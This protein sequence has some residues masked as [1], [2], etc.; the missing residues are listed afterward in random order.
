MIIV[1]LFEDYINSL[2][3]KKKTLGDILPELSKYAEKCKS[4]IDELEE[5][6][7]K[8]DS[9]MILEVIVDNIKSSINILDE[10]IDKITD[11]DKITIFFDEYKNSIV[12][13]AKDIVDILKKDENMVGIAKVID[14]IYQVYNDIVSNK[15][16]EYND[17][18]DDYRVSLKKIFD[19]IK[20]EVESKLSNFNIES[21]LQ[22]V[23]L[24]KSG[25]NTD[26]TYNSGDTVRYKMNN[27]DIN[28]A[29][30]SNNQESLKDTNNI[31]LYNKNS[32]QFE[33]DKSNIIEIVKRTA[34]ISSKIK[35]DLKDIS[36]DSG[37]LKKLSAFL[38]E[39]KSGSE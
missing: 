6:S 35:S 17:K 13:I 28:T 29:T 30:V 18:V 23:N 12:F 21:V 5:Y 24:D 32:E 4:V 27:G 2:S 11:N 20:S 26:I 9:D 10:Y 37:K 25:S 7:D 38:D 31:R 22:T 15:K 33:I 1:K 3:K 36:T 8:S 34:D 14:S 39:L 19:V 16:L